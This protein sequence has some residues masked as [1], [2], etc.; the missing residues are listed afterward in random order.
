MSAEAARKVPEPRTVTL[1]KTQ[2]ELGVQICGGNVRGIFVEKLEDDSPAKMA[3]GLAPG[4]MI[5][6]VGRELKLSY[7]K[8]GPVER[9]SAFFRVDCDAFFAFMH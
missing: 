7:G 1:R 8:L 5:L 4:D 6:E 9:S 2:V 3:D